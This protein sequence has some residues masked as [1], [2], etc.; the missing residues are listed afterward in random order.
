MSKVKAISRN[1]QIETGLTSNSDADFMSI[2][3]KGTIVKR[4]P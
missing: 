3:D 2:E 4:N 1:S